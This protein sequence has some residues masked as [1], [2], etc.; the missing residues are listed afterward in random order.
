MELKAVL[1]DEA[2]VERTVT[3]IAHE[4]LEKNHGTDNLA[5]IGVRRGGV[6]IA[7]RLAECIREIEGKEVPVGEIVTASQISGR[8][9]KVTWKKKTG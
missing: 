5:L 8:W 3:R 6:P 7:R 4:I 9:S 2:T 1:M